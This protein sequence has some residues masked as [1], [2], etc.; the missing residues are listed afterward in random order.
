MEVQMYLLNLP[1]LLCKRQRQRSPVMGQ[2]IL[3]STNEESKEQRF[4]ERKTINWVTIL[5]TSSFENALLFARLQLLLGSTLEQDKSS[6]Y[7]LEELQFI[8]GVEN[9]EI[10]VLKSIFKDSTDSTVVVTHE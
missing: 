9:A 4:L 1:Q 3:S 6:I 10:I 2:V 7:V 5:K 8:P